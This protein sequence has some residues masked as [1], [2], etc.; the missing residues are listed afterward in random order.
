MQFFFTN[1]KS[2]FLLIVVMF[3]LSV[4]LIYALFLGPHFIHAQL[5]SPTNTINL[6]IG[7]K[8]TSLKANQIVPIGPLTIYGTSTDTKNTNCKVFVDW[9]DT[10]PMQ[11]V[12]GIGSGGLND[13]S[14]WTFTYTDRYHLIGE[15]NNELTS[16]ISCDRNQTSNSTTKFFS[17]NITGSTNITN[18]SVSRTHASHILQPFHP[19]DNISKAEDTKS[20]VYVEI[21]G[22]YSGNKN[23]NGE[24]KIIKFRTSSNMISS[25]ANKTQ[26]GQNNF[27]VKHHD[28]TE[29]IH[30]LVREKLDRLSDQF[31][32]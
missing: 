21:T 19:V 25:K 9:N 30:N 20:N 24:D 27:D 23:N 2:V 18:S 8:I 7:V 15:G 32:H 11:N 13:Y 14:K 12:T 3:M 10:K 17:V 29:F 26:D 1:L 28:L 31:V 4:L 5:G 6:K 16:K 22:E